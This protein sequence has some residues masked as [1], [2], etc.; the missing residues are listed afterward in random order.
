MS[1]HKPAQP[2]TVVSETTFSLLLIT[3]RIAL[4]VILPLP[5]PVA[6]TFVADYA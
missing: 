2:S 4:F 6:S 1:L 3:L 5:N